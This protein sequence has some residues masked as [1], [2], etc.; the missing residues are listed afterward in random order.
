MNNNLKKNDPRAPSQSE[1]IA[2]FIKTQEN[3][4]IIRAQE[5]ELKKQTDANSYEYAIKAL[6]ANVLDRQSER[7]HNQ[8]VAKGRYI[9]A[10]VVIV[11]L[12]ILFA[13][14]LFLNKDAIVME[15]IKAILYITTGGIGGYSLAKTKGKSDP[16]NGG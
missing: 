12:F 5:L 3:E 9:F 8:S 11:A 4:L 2:Q 1:L 7:N 14:A 13:I 15:I 6:D 10:G 16:P